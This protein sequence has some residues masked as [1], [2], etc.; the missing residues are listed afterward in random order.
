VY[1][2]GTEDHLNAFSV[3]SL[4]VAVDYDAIRAIGGHVPGTV[5]LPVKVTNSDPNIVLDDP[6]TSIEA[7]VD[8]SASASETVSV[9]VS[10]TPPPGYQVGTATATPSTV[11]ATGPEHQL[12]GVHVETQQIDLS[13][14]RADFDGTVAV[15]P[16]D[17]AG[18]LLSDVN[19]SPSTVSVEITVNGVD[20]SR[21]SSVVL[22]PI[23]GAAGSQVFVSYSPMT[24]T[25]MGSQ[26]LINDPS[27]ATVTTNAIDVSGLTGSG[28]YRVSIE[29]PTG[30]TVSPTSV[31]V[32]ITV[33]PIPTP[34]PSATPAP[35]PTP[36]SPSG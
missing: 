9:E 5:R 4:Q 16:Y 29:A 13:N 35:T 2:T 36:T 6:P 31:T 1:I 24:V 22:G 12:I 19:V 3:S 30:I 15:Y 27:L 7:D 11:T 18:R 32:T 21:T 23:T 20:T 26:D 8:S 34:T 28:T 17:S 25:L 10:H 33:T 14:Q